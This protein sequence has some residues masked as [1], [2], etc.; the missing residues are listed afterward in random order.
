MLRRFLLLVLLILIWCILNASFSLQTVATG[1]IASIITLFVKQAVQ[2]TSTKVFSYMTSPFVLIKFFLIVLYNIYISTF[3][4][5]K[6]ILQG[7]INPQFVSTTTKIKKPWLQALIANAVTMTP[8]TVTVD[9]SG[10][11]Y[12]ILWLYPKSIREKDIK[13][14]VIQDFE[15]ALIKEDLKD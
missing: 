13:K 10:H 1:S 11:T 6:D 2:P 12:T 5:I 8:G 9:M 4:A 3:R 7:N 14:H 15:N